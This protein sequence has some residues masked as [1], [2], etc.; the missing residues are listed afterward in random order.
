MPLIVL[1]VL[2]LGG[3][4]YARTRAP[5]DECAQPEQFLDANAFDPPLVLHTEGPR[6]TNL[7]RGR[8]TASWSGTSERPGGIAVSIVRTQGLP[9]LLLQ[10]AMALPGRNEPDDVEAGV[11]DTTEGR[12]PVHYAYERRGREVRITA[13]FMAHRREATTSPIWTRLRDGPSALANGSW[14]ITLFAAAVHGHVSQIDDRRDRLDDW[15]REA[16]VHYRGVC[17]AS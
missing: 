10:P 8:L 3:T 15:L 6:A 1:L 4:F 11:L 13:Y 14:P 9:N 12:I 5:R 7:D 2:A 17:T 16:W